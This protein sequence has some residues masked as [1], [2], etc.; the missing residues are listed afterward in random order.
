MTLIR[1]VPWLIGL[2]GVGY[3]FAQKQKLAPELN[4]ISKEA[5]PYVQAGVILFGAYVILTDIVG[6]RHE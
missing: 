6:A 3:L 5:L 1:I 4:K 2:G